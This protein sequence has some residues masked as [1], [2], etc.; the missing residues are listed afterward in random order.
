MPESNG[1]AVQTRAL[2][3]T[4]FDTWKADQ[5]LSSKRRILGGSIPAWVACALSIG[6]LIWGAAVISS[7]VSE[8]RRRIEAVES[9]QMQQ[10]RD[11]QASRD[12]LAR[13]EAKID[14][15]MGERK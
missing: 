3:Q 4:L 2:A 5:D 13:I 6:T 9:Q 14:V 10:A 12:R 7:D 8:N 11:D 1:N 15:L